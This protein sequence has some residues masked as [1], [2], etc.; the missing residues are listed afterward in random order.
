MFVRPADG[1]LKGGEIDI[2][3]GVHDNQHNQVA[4]HTAP[5][6]FESHITL[7][8][9]LTILGCLLN[10]TAGFTGTISVSPPPQVQVDSNCCILS[11]RAVA[12]IIPIAIRL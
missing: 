2:I 7:A 4:W 3:E 8:N 6:R 9:C 12:K 11:S 5:G 1:P 10:T